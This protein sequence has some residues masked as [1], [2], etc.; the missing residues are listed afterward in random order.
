MNLLGWSHRS[1]ADAFAGVAPA[2]GGA[3]RL[4]ELDATPPGV[5]CSADAAGLAR[6]PGCCTG[7]PTTPAGR[8]LVRAEIEHV[9]IVETGGS[10]ADARSAAATA[11]LEA[12]VRPP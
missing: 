3:F 1:L 6:A 7:D 9:E 5:R 12:D 8:L 10:D 4:G 2:P 11:R